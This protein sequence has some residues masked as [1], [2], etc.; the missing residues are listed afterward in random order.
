MCY[1]FSEPIWS[2]DSGPKHESANALLGTVCVMIEVTLSGF[3]SIYFEK[4]IKSDAEQY[5][6]WER[7]FQLALWSFPL[8]VG[9]IFF[10]PGA[11]PSNIGS[12]WSVMA[13]S[14]SALGASGGLLV[15]LSIK[16]GDSVLKTLATTSAIIL[17]AIC[18]HIWLGGPLSIV[19]C[20]AAAQV[21]ISIANYAFDAT[22]AAHTPIKDVSV[23]KKIVEKV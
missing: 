19:M 14:L 8:Y 1:F 9:F 11:D 23:E 4:V 17:S 21:I 22:P 18:D 12:G 6:I 16:Y 15:A 7:N 20:I 5:G 3:A 13:F 2:K 10:G